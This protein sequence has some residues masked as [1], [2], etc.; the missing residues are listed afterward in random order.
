MNVV[1]G[2]DVTEKRVSVRLV[3]VDGK[4]M[5]G[6]LQDIGREGE[7]AFQQ[8][9]RS[10]AASGQ[11]IQNAAFQIG[12]V[13]TQVTAGTDP[14]RAIAIQLPQLLGG[15]GVFGAVAGATA[16]ALLPLIG[17]LFGVEDGGENVSKVMDGLTKAHDAYR[18]ALD[19]TQAPMAELR[20]KFGE[21]AED[22]RKLQLILLAISQIE[23]AESLGKATET[24]SSNLE[25]IRGAVAEIAENQQYIGTS[26]EADA[27]SIIAG[28]QE[29]LREEFG[30]TVEE[31]NRIVAA[32]DDLENAKSPEQVLAALQEMASALM[33]G[34]DASGEMNPELAAVG[35]AAAEAAIQG[36]S[37]QRALEAGETAAAGLA[38]TDMAGGV[39]A[40]ASE[41]LLLAQRLNLSLATAVRLAALGDQGVRA[42]DGPISSGRGGDPRTMGG[43]ALD[44]QVYEADQWLKAW[45]EAQK[46][47]GGRGGGGGGGASAADK[48]RKDLEREA[49]RLFD[50][51]RTAAERY[52]IEMADLNKLQ[53]AGLITTETYGRAVK[54]LQDDYAAA[55]K[56][57]KFWKD[58]MGDLKTDMVDAIASGDDL[59]DVFGNIA[60]SIEKAAL[61]AALFGEGPLAGAGGWSLFGGGG[62]GGG[63]GSWLSGLL[64]FDGGGS[65]P[66]GPRSGGL[67]G[68]G[69]FLAML[70]P[71]ESVTDHRRAGRSGRNETLNINLGPGLQAEW[72][73]QAAQASYMIAEGV[74]QRQSRQLPGALRNI[75]LRGTP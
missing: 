4:K 39:S 12:D 34:R 53:E 64:S 47:T 10:S 75:Q 16:A 5:K 60:R 71:D 65:T 22:A 25:G 45:K 38:S 59:S 33:A 24:I 15:F 19:A 35:K 74:S 14:M 6:E 41:A 56:T 13:F 51:T 28:Q 1:T 66:S 52:S 23:Y 70:H 67:D 69:G 27:L 29:E 37:M 8:I 11:R 2:A 31:A 44:V 3:V 9:E 42:Y 40:A 46:S 68:R 62:T 54:K 30:L 49:A 50:S 26:V 7:K 72:Q 61:Q 17:N 20:D 63:F 73:G 21:N 18:A 57:A 43:S 58:T 32:M 48:E 36:L 55:D